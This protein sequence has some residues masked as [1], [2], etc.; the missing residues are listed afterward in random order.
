M[1]PDGDALPEEDRGKTGLALIST[2]ED[3]DS[4]SFGEALR[5]RNFWFFCTAES[6]RLMV[7]VSIVLHVMPYFDSLGIPR[8]ISGL[9]AGGLAVFSVLGRLGFGFLGD[10]YD[11]RHITNFSFALM[12]LGL[13]VY[14][15]FIKGNW[16]LFLFLIRFAPGFGGG[17]TRR[18]ALLR[19]Y[20]GTGSYGKIMGLTMGIGSLASII[21]PVLA[22]WVY[23]TSGNY[24]LLWFIYIGLCVL[25]IL[26]VTGIRTKKKRG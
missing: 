26:F 12:T 15:F 1:L 7:V 24:Q 14:A 2:R 20:F 22:G 16:S 13:I 23:D 5:D 8:S 19:E 25:G 3:T 17:M 11:K 4:V 9:V 6:I 10:Y 18:G 21:G